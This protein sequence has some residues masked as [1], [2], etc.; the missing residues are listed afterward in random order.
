MVYNKL[1]M[2][3][4][5]AVLFSLFGLSQAKPTQDRVLSLRLMNDG[6]NFPF[7]VYSGYLNISSEKKLHYMFLES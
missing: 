2:K 6:K 5:T 1:K 3:N 4:L 7:E